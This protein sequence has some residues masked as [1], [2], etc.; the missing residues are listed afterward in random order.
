MLLLTLAL[1]ALLAHPG[2]YGGVETGIALSL[3]AMAAMLLK[4]MRLPLLS[5]LLIGVAGVFHGFAHGLEMAGSLAYVGFFCQQYQSVIAGFSD[6]S[7]LGA[8][9][10]TT[11]FW[12]YF[13]DPRFMAVVGRLVLQRP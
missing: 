6:R 12:R 9:H 4:P 3:L 7:L 1:G 5:A 8:P 2:F 11:P 13:I 10:D